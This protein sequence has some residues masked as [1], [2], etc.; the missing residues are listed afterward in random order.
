MWAALQDMKLS[1]SWGL[2]PASS[3]L[4]TSAAKQLAVLLLAHSFPSFFN[5]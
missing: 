4:M 3:T 5:Q 2:F 1:P